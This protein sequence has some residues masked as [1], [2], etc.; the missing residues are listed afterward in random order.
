[1]H[2]VWRS[3]VYDSTASA[4][5]ESTVTRTLFETV[6]SLT[7]RCHPGDGVGRDDVHN[8]Y[9]IDRFTFYVFGPEDSLLSTGHSFAAF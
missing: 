2:V 1:M 7:D 8:T 3:V 9:S 5:S 6:A 4:R